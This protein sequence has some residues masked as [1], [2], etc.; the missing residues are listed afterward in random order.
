M[1]RAAAL[2]LVTAALGVAVAGCG[3]EP[4]PVTQQA[5]DGQTF[6]SASVEGYTLAPKTQLRLDFEGGRL[7]A[8]AGCNTIAGPYTVVKNVL[9]QG[10]QAQTQMA[11]GDRVDAQERWFAGFLS[12]GAKATLLEHTLTLQGRGVKIVFTQARASK[13]PAVVGTKWTLIEAEPRGA[14]AIPVPAAKAPTLELNDRG[15]ARLFGGCNG[16]GGEATFAD[17][18]VTFG[19]ILTTQ[20]A[21]EPSVMTLERF[22]LKVLAGKVAAGFSGEGEL[23]LAK[24]GDRLLFRAK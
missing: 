1:L 3:D 21:C 14:A 11:C 22:F 17:G 10:Q 18:F 19:P 9:K 24:D 2:V 6:A 8:N 20:M 13:L 15:E 23:S 16:G 4:T 5:L 7:A 12:T